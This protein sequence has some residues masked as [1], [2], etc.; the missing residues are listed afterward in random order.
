[1]KVVGAAEKYDDRRR[2]RDHVGVYALQHTVGSVARDTSVDRAEIGVKSVEVA[3]FSQRIAE[4]NYPAKDWH[5]VYV[6]EIT[7]IYTA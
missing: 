3:E 5:D 6:A 1:M 4:K 2:Q 7:D